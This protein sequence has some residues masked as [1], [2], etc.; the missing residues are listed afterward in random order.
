MLGHERDNGSPRVTASKAASEKLSIV[1][2]EITVDAKQRLNAFRTS[3]KG[4]VLWPR[5]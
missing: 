5:G 4:A 1:M 3:Q 2:V